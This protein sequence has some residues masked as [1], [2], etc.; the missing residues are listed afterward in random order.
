MPITIQDQLKVLIELQKIDA[1]IYRLKKEFDAFP[2]EQKKLEADFEKKRAALKAAEE[3]LKAFQMK[4]REKDNELLSKE[5][6]IKKLQ[7]QLYQLKSNKEYAAMELEIKGGKADKSLLEEDILMLMDE[8]ERAK[9]KCAGEKEVL[10]REEKKLK[11]ETGAIQKR[12]AEIVSQI[13][14]REDSRKSYL[15]GVEPGLLA[16]YEKMVRSREGLGLVPVR[17]NSCGGCHIGL[18]PQ[19]VNEIQIGE[20]LIACESCARIIY[21]PS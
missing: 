17:N 21:W 7:T 13:A 11:E 20:K 19:I 10:T 8:V 5:D 14:A 1:E 9:Q 6:K 2:A 3:E 18:P 16:Q 4:Q 15:P 12:A